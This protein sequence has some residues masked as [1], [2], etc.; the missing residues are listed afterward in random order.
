MW[1]SVILAFFHV[2]IDRSGRKLG[3]G[4]LLDISLR[5][6]YHAVH[7]LL[8]L[9]PLYDPHDGED[10]KVDDD[11]AANSNADDCSC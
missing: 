7:E 4:V 9:T 8:A 5:L 1:R 3:V 6:S 10:D 2:R 11:D